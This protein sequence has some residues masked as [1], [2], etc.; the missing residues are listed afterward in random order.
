MNNRH[1]CQRQ[2]A[3]IETHP[4]VETHNLARSQM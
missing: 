2:E 4:L 1:G 3:K